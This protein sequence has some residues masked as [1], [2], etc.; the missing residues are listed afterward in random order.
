MPL[1]AWLDDVF[2]TIGNRWGEFVHLD[3]DKAERNR[4]D[5]AKILISISCLSVIPP[6]CSIELN[7]SLF[8]LKLSK[9][10]FEDERCWIDNEK[11]DSHLGCISSSSCSSPRLPSIGKELSGDLK[12]LENE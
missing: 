2:H 1:V 9:A 4:F 8:N 6:S 11:S 10:E 3:V 12:N 5:V 7:G